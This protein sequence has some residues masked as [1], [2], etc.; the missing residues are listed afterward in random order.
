MSVTDLSGPAMDA[1]AEALR[2]SILD[3]GDQ[4]LLLECGSIEGVLA[5]TQAVRAAAWPGVVDIVRPH[6]PCCSSSTARACRPSCV[7]ACENC[8]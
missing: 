4:A 6:A 3:Y 8:G 7:T 2:C 1:S 5:W